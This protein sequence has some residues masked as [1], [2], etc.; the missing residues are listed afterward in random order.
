MPGEFIIGCAPYLASNTDELAANVSVE[1]GLMMALCGKLINKA[2]IPE[3]YSRKINDC[4][5]V[6]EYLNK[7]LFVALLKNF[8]CIGMVHDFTDYQRGNLHT[9]ALPERTQVVW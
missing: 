5:A 4:I 6:I 2:R 3:I 7:F 8:T 1:K 9:G